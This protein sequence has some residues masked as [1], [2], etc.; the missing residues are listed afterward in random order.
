MDFSTQN[1][2]H[3]PTR[4]RLSELPDLALAHVFSHL[5]TTEAA[6]T[7][8][9]SKR[10]NSLWNSVD[11]L[12]FSDEFTGNDGVVFISIVDAALGF[13]RQTFIREFELN[14]DYDFMYRNSVDFWINFAFRKQVDYLNCECD[15]IAFVSIKKHIEVF[16]EM[17]I[18]EVL[19]V[20]SL[21]LNFRRIHG[22]RFGDVRYTMP[23]ILHTNVN[24]EELVICRCDFS[25]KLNIS[26][27]RLRM[28]SMTQTRLSDELISR[29]LG[30]CS[31]L[32]TLELIDCTGFD[33][34]KI[35]STSL[36]VLHIVGE[37]SP[38]FWLLEEADC[39]LEIS[40]PYLVCLEVSGM[41]YRTKLRLFDVGSL[42]KAVMSFT[43]MAQKSDNK[44]R[45]LATRLE[46][47]VATEV[48]ESLSSVKQ[49][50]VGGSIIKGLSTCATYN[51]SS[52]F[53][54]RR[55]LTL[56]I[57]YIE[58]SH[59]GIANLVHVSPNLESLVFKLS[60]C[61]DTCFVGHAGVPPENKDHENYWK[62][63]SAISKCP[64]LHLKIVKVVGF[65]LSCRYMKPLFE[66]LGFMLTNSR[67]LEK[68]VIHASRYVTRAARDEVM[69][70]LVTPTTSPSAIVQFEPP[71]FWVD[72]L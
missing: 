12:R 64:L 22:D 47:V 58:W 29:I 51:L 43:I 53:S 67:A 37:Q 7:S 35:D 21:H 42:V 15:L 27:S 40:G 63:S 5:L 17:K 62:S 6:R 23:E 16:V 44:N 19:Q 71:H 50:T 57:P 4:D 36:R 34:L 60:Y 59:H 72:P 65:Q 8:I 48:L 28:L 30:G 20:K 38:N 18:A 24:L 3:H 66:F 32:E 61:S 13:Y 41:L 10:F 55:S 11:S 26:C 52:R 25:K 31:V 68:I 70:L 46:Y 1:P 69:K 39:V 2:N 14:F 54:E 56:C 33:K 9:L 49:L 45:Q